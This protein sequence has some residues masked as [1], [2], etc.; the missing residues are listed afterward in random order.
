MANTATSIIAQ[1]LKDVGTS[2]RPNHITRDYSQRHGNGFLQAPWC[3]MAVT[4]WARRSGALAALPG[5]DRAY[6]VWHAEDFKRQGT[7]FEGTATN[8]K[9]AKPGDIVFFDWDG[10]NT[11]SRIDHVGV[12]QRNLNDGRL[13]VI[14]GN[15]SD[16]CAIRVRSYDVIAG[17]GRPK[18]VTS[19]APPP[20]PTPTT[21]PAYPGKLVRKG[22]MDSS[23]VK[24]C[25]ARLNALGYRPPLAVDGDFGAKTETAVKWFQGKHGLA[26]DG[27]IGPKTYAKL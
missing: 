25:Q 5:G 4:Y 16:R 22:W 8:V 24:W 20:K 26:K 23:F 14:E 11:L 15:T 21:K 27:I 10:T 3:D 19:S 6:T 13:V 9:K 17:Y 12:V 7:W 2:G 18:Y 1:A